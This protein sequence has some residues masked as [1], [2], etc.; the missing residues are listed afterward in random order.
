MFWLW[1]EIEI[2]AYHPLDIAATLTPKSNKDRQWKAEWVFSIYNLYRKK[3]LLSISDK[4]Q[5][6]EPMKL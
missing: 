1:I 4:I 5:I 2:V 3:P 6:P